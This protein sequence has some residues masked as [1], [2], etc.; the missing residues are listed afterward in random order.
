MWPNIGDHSACTD[1]AIVSRALAHPD[2]IW[3]VVVPQARGG[4]GG[5]RAHGA[6]ARAP[7]A[8]V[9][10]GGRAAPRGPARRGGG[11][12]GARAPRAPRRRRATRPS[13][14]AHL[15]QVQPAVHGL[16]GVLDLCSSSLLSS[17]A[18]ARP[19][20]RRDECD[21]L[22]LSSRGWKWDDETWPRSGE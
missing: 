12:G 21:L 13:P 3:S 1:S 7:P 5:A 14:R 2:S 16:E 15:P 9:P 22:N 19:G 18:R 4:L 10:A 11:G 6:R 20:G 17:V 8:R